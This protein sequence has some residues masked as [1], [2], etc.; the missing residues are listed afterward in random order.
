M[1]DTGSQERAAASILMSRYLNDWEDL[2]GAI[3]VGIVDED[4]ARSMEGGRLIDTF[5]GFRQVI[6]G[7][8]EEHKRAQLALGAQNAAMPFAHV[9]YTEMQ[10]VAMRWHEIRH[11]EKKLQDDRMEAANRLADAV[12]REG[13]RSSVM[14]KA[15]GNLD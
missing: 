1:R 13:T 14:P 6:D 9:P 5:F 15:K 2:C 10:D 11:N 7:F 12:Q 3:S 8:R 4:Y